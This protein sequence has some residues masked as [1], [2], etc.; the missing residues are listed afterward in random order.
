MKRHINRYLLTVLSSLML[1][2]CSVDEK[3]EF[4]ASPN[5]SE[6]IGSWYYEDSNGSQI[7]RIIYN[8]HHDGTY[9]FEAIDMPNILDVKTTEEK[10]TGIYHI[11]DNNLRMGQKITDSNYGWL[12]PVTF[13]REGSKLK[14]VSKF[15]L[16]TRTFNLITDS[17]TIGKGETILFKD[18]DIYGKPESFTSSSNLVATVSENGMI[19]A[20]NIGIAYITGHCKNNDVV[21]KIKVTDNDKITP[22][23]IEDIWMPK[24]SI[25]EKYGSN[26]LPGLNSTTSGQLNYVYGSDQIK[27]IVFDFNAKNRLRGIGV[28]Y[29]P[30]VNM[31]K[32]KEYIDHNYTYLEN[33]KNGITYTKEIGQRTYECAIDTLK[34]MIFYAIKSIDYDEYDEA[35]YL[36]RN[37]LIFPEGSEILAQNPGYTDAKIA[38]NK[39]FD[40]ILVRYNV[41]TGEILWIKL[42]AKDHITSN[43]LYRWLNTNYFSSTDGN[44]I[45]TYFNKKDIWNMRP[46]VWINVIRFENGK[47]GLQYSK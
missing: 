37:E 1:L 29:W 42:V 11:S 7:K 2:S 32:F 43:D 19:K 40:R 6:I 33:N 46:T 10:G 36:R 27:Q 30:S 9:S 38:G 15:D 21:I 39:I 45:T 14:L 22:D 3:E 5:Q 4:Q 47:F 8:Y 23:F 18:H 13:T 12:D 20:T 31:A 25:I 16:T 34:R 26:Y 24:D 35:I 17:C 41:I 28:T 44:G